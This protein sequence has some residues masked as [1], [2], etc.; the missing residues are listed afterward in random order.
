VLGA[1]LPLSGVNAECVSMDTTGTTVVTIVV[2]ALIQKKTLFV[3]FAM[4]TAG[5]IGVCLRKH[6]A[7]GIRLQVVKQLNA[8]KS[9]GI[10]SG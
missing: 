2:V 6:G 5:T 4:A 1:V 8:V 10:R 3:S 9:N 7:R